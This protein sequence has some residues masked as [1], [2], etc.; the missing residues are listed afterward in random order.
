[1]VSD[2]S[3]TRTALQHEHEQLTPEAARPA[4]DHY[5]LEQKN[6]R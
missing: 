5:F 2:K 6:Y 1:M 4:T 3:M